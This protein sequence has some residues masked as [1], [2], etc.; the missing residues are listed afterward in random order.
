[1]NGEIIFSIMAKFE[2]AKNVACKCGD[3]L[4]SE[5]GYFLPIQ[6]LP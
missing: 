2:M 6:V 3:N 4:Q 5:M 1:M